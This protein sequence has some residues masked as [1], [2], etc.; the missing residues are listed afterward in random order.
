MSNQNLF[1]EKQTKRLNNY[2]STIYAISLKQRNSQVVG[3]LRDDPGRG[4]TYP[5]ATHSFTG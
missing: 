3:E 4:V 1:I 2:H 5:L